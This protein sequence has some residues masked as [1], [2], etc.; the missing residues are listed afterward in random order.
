MHYDNIQKRINSLN[1]LTN[2]SGYK[3]YSM[4]KCGIFGFSYNT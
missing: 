3:S 1:E 2:E 4:I